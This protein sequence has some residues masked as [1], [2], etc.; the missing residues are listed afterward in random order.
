MSQAK[1][2]QSK[3]EPKKKKPETVLAQIEP[4]IRCPHCFY[5]LMMT[6]H[7][8][9][10]IKKNVLTCLNH[11]CVGHQVKYEYPKVQLTIIKEVE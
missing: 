5:V 8:E 9:N 4:Q 11:K 2:N 7:V 10:R 1:A 3:S 6:D